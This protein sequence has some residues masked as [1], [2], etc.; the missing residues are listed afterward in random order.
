MNEIIQ[1]Y[2]WERIYKS[3]ETAHSLCKSEVLC[4]IPY[5]NVKIVGSA[6]DL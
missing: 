6:E 3:G 5:T 4:L 1:T 2:D